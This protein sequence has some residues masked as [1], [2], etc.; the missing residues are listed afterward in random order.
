MLLK[1]SPANVHIQGLSYE[2]HQNI[3]PL[4][5]CV[6]S[7]AL[8]Y[9]IIEEL[10]DIRERVLIHG[11]NHGEVTDHKVEDAPADRDLLVRVSGLI[12]GLLDL[13]S[14]NQALRNE[15]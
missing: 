6:S 8:H 5:K 10:F 7:R 4:L 15:F 1:Q 14:L 9:G 13:F 11:I 3:Y 2:F 12:D